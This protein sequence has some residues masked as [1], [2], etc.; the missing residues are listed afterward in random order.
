M[1]RSSG[2]RFG[3]L[4]AL[5]L[6]GPARPV[7]VIVFN[8]LIMNN[9]FGALRILPARGFYGREGGEAAGMRNLKL[10]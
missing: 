5:G 6:L 1:A 7:T 3:T 2:V 10:I 4:M 9:L 8:L